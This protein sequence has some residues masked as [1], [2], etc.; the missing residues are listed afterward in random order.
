MVLFY[1]I[2]IKEV[3][4][5]MVKKGFCDVI[6]VIRAEVLMDFCSRSFD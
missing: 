6:V 1:E 4:G 2:R 3:I 5:W